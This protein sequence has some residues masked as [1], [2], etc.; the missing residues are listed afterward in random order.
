MTVL[1]FGQADSGFDRDEM[2]MPAR[3]RLGANHSS[4]S[5]IVL[6]NDGYILTS[7][8][9]VVGAQETMVIVQGQRRLPAEI[10]GL[11]RRTDVAVL[12]VAASNLPAA[13]VD[14]SARLCPGE[15][16][17]ALGA[18]FGFELS[19][20]AGVVSA[21]PRFLP[22]G[23]GVP[24]IQTDVALNPGN[25]G[26]PLFNERGEVVGMNSMIYSV[27]G[28]YQGVSFSLP[29]DTA[30]RIATELRSNGRVTRGQIGARTQALTSDLAPAFG[31]DRPLGALIVHVDPAGS[32]EGAGLRSGDVVLA[33]N[34]S[35][36]LAYAE[37]QERVAATA[38]GSSLTL[39][40]WRHKAPL[41]VTVAV[42]ESQP[43]FPQRAAAF[44]DPS[45]LRLGL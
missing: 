19:V 5:G 12:K 32:A 33:V 34:G 3:S 27:S 40:V 44:A 8:H 41:T 43:D 10:V 18:P 23:N 17:A 42:K 37:I 31:L 45:E 36:A 24:L 1:V 2:R 35:T 16:V 25:S 28:G 7:A 26:G 30:V 9:A 29:I 22:A 21:N 15:W 11:D 20:T 38:P 13:A 4:A 14:S 6:S 39:G